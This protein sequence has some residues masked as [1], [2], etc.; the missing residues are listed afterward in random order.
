MK[1]T[2]DTIT[3]TTIRDPSGKLI[4]AARIAAAKADMSMNQWLCRMI[5]AATATSDPTQPLSHY[6]GTLCC[7]PEAKP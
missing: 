5:D 7:R 1:R 2:H 6:T 4:L 3:I